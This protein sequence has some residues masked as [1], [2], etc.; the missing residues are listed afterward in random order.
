MGRGRLLPTACPKSDSQGRIASRDAQFVGSTFT[1]I[2]LRIYEITKA[3]F[4]ETFKIMQIQQLYHARI[5]FRI[6]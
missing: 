2:S 4:A 3:I 5:G 6:G 1:Q